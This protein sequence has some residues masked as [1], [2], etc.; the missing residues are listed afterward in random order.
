MAEIGVES[1]LI[2]M[3]PALIAMAFVVWTRGVLETR[4]W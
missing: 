1:I 2:K 3:L 4:T